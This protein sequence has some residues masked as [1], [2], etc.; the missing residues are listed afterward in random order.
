MLSAITAT[1]NN[2]SEKALEELQKGILE[3]VIVQGA[4]GHLVVQGIG[5]SAILAVLANKSAK[6]GLLYLLV[7]RVSETLGDFM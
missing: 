1:I 7:S 5:K 2:V 6:P 3:V 4:Q